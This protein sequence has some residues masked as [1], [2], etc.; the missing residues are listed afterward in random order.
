[1][2]GALPWDEV[3]LVR[4]VDGDTVLLAMR[5][6]VEADPDWLL[7]RRTAPTKGTRVRLVW[8][9]TPDL[10]DKA[11][12]AAATADTVRWFGFQAAAGR[13]LAANSY[14]RDEFARLLVDVYPVGRPEESLSRWLMTAGNAGAG[15]PPYVKGQ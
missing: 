14:G 13:P 4:V 7:E 12:K 15:W 1:M 5:R 3:T 8:V 9:D 10:P 11:G 2:S 6:T